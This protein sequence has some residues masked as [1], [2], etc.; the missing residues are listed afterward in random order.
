MSTIGYT[1]NTNSF[2]ITLVK[3][4][5]TSQITVTNRGIF[6][7]KFRWKVAATQITS[8]SPKKCLTIHRISFT[9]S[10]TGLYW[11]WI[12]T[13]FSCLAFHHE[14][15]WPYIF[16]NSTSPMSRWSAICSENFTVCL[17]KSGFLQRGNACTVHYCIAKHSIMY[18]SI[19]YKHCT[20]LPGHLFNQ[21]QGGTTDMRKMPVY[22]QV[23]C[24]GYT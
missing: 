13:F 19:Q 9:P 12:V 21:K 17:S 15:R 8:K 4:I 23:T 10:F 22:S 14:K 5:S 2:V 20:M 24:G 1:P 7:V 16:A 3:K 6:T 18:T 11:W